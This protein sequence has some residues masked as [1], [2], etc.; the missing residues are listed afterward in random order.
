MVRFCAATLSKLFA[1]CTT[2]LLSGEYTPAV[3]TVSVTSRFVLVPP[4]ATGPKLPAVT[5]L[6]LRRESVMLPPWTLVWSAPRR[7]GPPALTLPIW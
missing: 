3:A 5:P 7:L 1:M 6:P 4:A 2:W